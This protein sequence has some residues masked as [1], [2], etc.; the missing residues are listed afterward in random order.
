MDYVVPLLE[1][2]GFIIPFVVYV[3]K[4]SKNEQRQ[5]DRLEQLEKRCDKLE[6][7]HASF[8]VMLHNIEN[9]LARI[10]T[11]VD[12]IIGGHK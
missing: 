6:G 7:N 1:A 3:N 2:V 12:M 4:V 11:K 5:E 9:N 10:E 8:A